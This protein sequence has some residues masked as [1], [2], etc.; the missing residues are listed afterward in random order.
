MP[1]RGLLKGA[2]ALTREPKHGSAGLN[3]GGYGRMSQR[4]ASV[5]AAQMNAKL[6]PSIPD[7]GSW[8]ALGLSFQGLRSE[9]RACCGA[10]DLETL[11]QVRYL[12]ELGYCFRSCTWQRLP[13]KYDVSCFNQAL[14]STPRQPR[15]K[16][17]TFAHHSLQH[18]PACLHAQRKHGFAFCLLR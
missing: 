18:R 11:V 16:L 14:G 8:V 2:K 12:L 7:F 4:D 1:V 6:I 10:H 9:L 3:K 5:S 15:S 17:V 13:D